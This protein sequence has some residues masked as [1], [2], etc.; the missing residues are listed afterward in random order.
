MIGAYNMY[1]SFAQTAS[2]IIFG[3]LA[4]LYNAKANPAMY[5]RL[6]IAFV[7]SGY[8]PSA[9]LYWIAGKKYVTHQ[10]EQKAKEDGQ[11]VVA[12]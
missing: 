9:L 5:G 6:I 3:Y 12:A 4:A 11:A 8:L 1:T 10:A 7:L 2:P